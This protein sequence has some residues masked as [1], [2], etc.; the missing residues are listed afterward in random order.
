MSR[1]AWSVALVLA[2]EAG[3][4]RADPALARGAPESLHAPEPWVFDMACTEDSTGVVLLRFATCGD[5][6]CPETFDGYHVI[7]KH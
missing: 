5:V 4:A 6:S 3:P 2:L 1:R 7:K